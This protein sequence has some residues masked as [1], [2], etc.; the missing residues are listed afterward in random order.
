MISS[1]EWATTG[2]HTLRGG[3]SIWCFQEVLYKIINK[4]NKNDSKPVAG[5]F[6]YGCSGVYNVTMIGLMYL[7]VATV[8]MNGRGGKEGD[9]V[10]PVFCVQTIGHVGLIKD[11]SSKMTINSD[12]DW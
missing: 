10:S 12:S 2:H 5:T 6:G 11:A 8:I 7:T 3:K 9:G 1:A 4:I